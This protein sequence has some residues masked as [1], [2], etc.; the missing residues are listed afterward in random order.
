M[1]LRNEPPKWEDVA[2]NFDLEGGEL[3]DLFVRSAPAN[4]WDVVIQIVRENRYPARFAIHGAECPLPASYSAIP[5]E[6]RRDLAPSMRFKIGSATIKVFFFGKTEIEISVCAWEVRDA[7]TF[8][9]LCEFV[10]RLGD[11][12]DQPVV[13]VEELDPENEFLTYRPT[14]PHWEYRENRLDPHGSTSRP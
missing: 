2:G 7:A 11:R 8:A 13:W 3:V 1:Q 14:E 10:R 9:D 5:E 4:A 12:L 6:L